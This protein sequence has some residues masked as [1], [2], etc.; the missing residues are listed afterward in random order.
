MGDFDVVTDRRAA[1]VAFALECARRRRARR[2]GARRADA[3]RRHPGP[4]GLGRHRG[5]GHPARAR[6]GPR[7]LPRLVG[8]GGRRLRRVDPGPGRGMG[9]HRGASRP[10][11][12]RRPGRRHPPRRRPGGVGGRAAA[13]GRRAL[14]PPTSC[15][16]RPS[17]G[18]GSRSATAT[19]RGSGS[20][21]ADPGLG[22]TC[23][24]WPPSS[25]G[26]RRHGPLGLRRRR[27]HHRR[28]APRRRGSEHARPR[29]RRGPGVPTARGPRRRPSGVGPLR[30][31][32]RDAGR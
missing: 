27:G 25:P 6:R 18:V 20:T 12:G 5:L 11:P 32:R 2:D 24:R 4:H 14:E 23:R 30:G 21:A 15:G 31:R 7:A 8:G 28:A 13:P 26:R 9:E 10:R 1:L 3:R 29:G 22:S 16:W 19:S 17:P